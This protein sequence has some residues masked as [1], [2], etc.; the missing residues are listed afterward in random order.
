MAKRT[1]RKTQRRNVQPLDKRKCLDRKLADA[2]TRKL[3]SD[4]LPNAREAEALRRLERESRKD[5]LREIV[6]ELPK[7]L[8]IECSHR[9]A[10]QINRQAARFGLPLD[11][12]T[13]DLFKLAPALHDLLAR[14]GS[15]LLANDDTDTLLTG[16]NS[17]AL[18]RFRE[19]RWRL[20]RLDRLERERV[21]L[22]RDDVHEFVT[23]LA[24]ILRGASERLERKFEYEALAIIDEALDNYDRLV[25]LEHAKN[26]D[27]EQGEA[28]V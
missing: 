15:K 12:R 9:Q 21:L 4:T 2:A 19:E 16:P 3:D 22:P 23:K 6:R 10:G 14:H 25:E 27:R 5:Q 8:W 18:E 1:K 20:A 24:A 17:P 26:I 13:V 28:D 11:G 7:W